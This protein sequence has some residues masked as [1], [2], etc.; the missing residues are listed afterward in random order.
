MS[1]TMTSAMFYWS[2]RL[3]IVHCVKGTQEHNWGPSWKLATTP[4]KTHSAQC[5]LL[6]VAS[7]NSPHANYALVT[8]ASDSP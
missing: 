2:H 3:T 5:D 1:H 6:P 7:P 4:T 8:W